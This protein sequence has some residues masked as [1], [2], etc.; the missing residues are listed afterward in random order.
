MTFNFYDWAGA[1]PASFHNNRPPVRRP[2]LV[3][4]WLRGA[5]GKLECRWVLVDPVTFID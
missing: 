3:A 2:R 5:D 4:H 1:V